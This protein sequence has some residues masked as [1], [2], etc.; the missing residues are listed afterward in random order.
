MELSG[1]HKREGHD[2]LGRHGKL[3]QHKH[4]SRLEQ[5]DKQLEQHRL[6]EI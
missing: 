1:Q 5:H 3:V 4:V 2:K 6:L